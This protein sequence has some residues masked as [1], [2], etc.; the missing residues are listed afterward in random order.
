MARDKQL[1]ANISLVTAGITIVWWFVVYLATLFQWTSKSF[2]FGQV[3]AGLNLCAIPLG[4]V[5]AIMSIAL[6][7]RQGLSHRLS[8]IALVANILLV[9]AFIAVVAIEIVAGD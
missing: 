9:L 5:T 7:P 1:L 2:P 8:V 3:F 4:V 6:Q